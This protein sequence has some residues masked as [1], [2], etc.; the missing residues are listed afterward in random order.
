MA[1]RIIV[2]W[3]IS[4]FFH[5]LEFASKMP[6]WNRDS[7]FWRSF[8]GYCGGNEYLFRRYAHTEQLLLQ[9]ETFRDTLA[10]HKSL[11]AIKH[12]EHD[13]SER[14]DRISPFVRQ[15]YHSIRSPDWRHRHRLFTYKAIKTTVI[16]VTSRTLKYFAQSVHTRNEKFKRFWIH[17]HRLLLNTWEYIFQL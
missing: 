1:L 17:I 3:N 15:I 12:T 14:Y 4:F 11:L 5:S 6:V 16:D 13:N 8:S 7:I 2:A 9:F 10:L